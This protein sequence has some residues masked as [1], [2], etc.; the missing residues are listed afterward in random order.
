MSMPA[1]ESK[2]SSINSRDPRPFWTETARRGLRPRS[3][4]ALTAEGRS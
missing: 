4:A 2:A 3:L 1:A